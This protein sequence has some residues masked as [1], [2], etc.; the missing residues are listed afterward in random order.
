MG[1]NLERYQK[2]LDR[3]IHEGDILANAIQ[4][5]CFPEQ[6][7]AQA[8]RVLKEKYK[9]VIKE[10]PSFADKYQEWYSESLAVIKLV[11]P[12]RV[13]DFVKH[14]EKP[15][16]RKQVSFENYVIED[17]LQGLTMT[18]TIG[19][20]KEKL[21]GPEAA[22]PRFRQQV[23][24]LKAVR[25]RFK[26]SLFDIKQ[27]LQA[28]LFDSELEAAKELNNKGFSRGAGAMAGVVLERHLS[29]V[30][31]NHKLGVKKSRPTINDFGQSLK[32]NEV[33]DLQEWR[34]IQHLAD[35]RNLCDHNKEKEP[36]KDEINELISGVE[37]V[38]KRVY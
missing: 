12:D 17:H 22:I 29:Q 3:L 10:L 30:C 38:S 11:L 14:Y 32:D 37:K 25:K 1:S 28:D 34:F 36:G 24:I 16:T 6:F 2:D 26:S 9:E 27:L 18:R 5:E 23:N 4:Y 31:E 21:V 35:L 20:E 33:I 8:K 19:L 7:E 13:Q 15:K